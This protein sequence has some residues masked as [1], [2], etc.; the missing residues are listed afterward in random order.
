MLN[1]EDP[2]AGPPQNGVADSDP[3]ETL[4]RGAPSGS[5]GKK[6]VVFVKSIAT[7]ATPIRRSS[8]NMQSK[9]TARKRFAIKVEKSDSVLQVKQQVGS[10]QSRVRMLLTLRRN[11]LRPRGT[12]S[13]S[14]NV[15]T[16]EARSSRTERRRSRILAFSKATPFI[17]EE[18]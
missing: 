15:S 11:R 6:A 17:S 4:Q 10:G 1:E 12:S 9:S 5:G 7:F 16:F 13:P 3:E 14:I 18:L 8:R 2:D